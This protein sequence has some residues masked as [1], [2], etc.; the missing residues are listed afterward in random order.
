[1]SV[2]HIY[3]T[4]LITISFHDMSSPNLRSFRSRVRVSGGGRIPVSVSFHVIFDTYLN[5]S[6]SKPSAPLAFTDRNAEESNPDSGRRGH[7]LRKDHLG[8]ETAKSVAQQL[9]HPPRRLCTG[10]QHRSLVIQ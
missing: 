4:W 10:K 7:L 6:W 1:M 5:L 8:E 3:V 9:Y 2:S